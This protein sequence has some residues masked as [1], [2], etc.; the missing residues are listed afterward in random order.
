MKAPGNSTRSP[1]IDAYIEGAPETA[2]ERLTILREVIRDEAPGA[3]EKISYG[4]PT[5]HQRENLVH[6]AG[7]ARHVGLYPGSGAIA[8]FA[9]ELTAYPTSKGTVQF[10]HDRDLPLELVR[11][12]V[13]WRVE[14]A[15]KRP[16]K[17]KSSRD[18]T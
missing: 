3:T 6:I 16:P 14:Q 5:W 17:R 15:A 9:E 12:I 18:G 11:R 8:A 13:R 4:I 1:E 10:A 7:Y 2:R